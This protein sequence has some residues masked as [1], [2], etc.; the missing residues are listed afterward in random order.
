M[1]ICPQCNAQLRFDPAQQKLVCDYCEGIFDPESLKESQRGATESPSDTDWEVIVF[2]C[3]QCGGEVYSTSTQG[4]GFCSFCGASATLQSRMAKAKRPDFIIPF[5]LTKEDCKKILAKRL[6]KAWFLPSALRQHTKVDSFRGIYMPYYLYRTNIEGH[7]TLERDT[8]RR[9]GNYLITTYY[10]IE[11]DISADYKWVYF[12]SSSSFDDSISTS[13]APYDLTSLKPFNTNYFSG[14]YAD[15]ADLPVNLFY[16]L[17]HGLTTALCAREL[18]NDSRL[19]KYYVQS[20]SLGDTT[21]SIEETRYALFP[22]WFLA[23]RSLDRIA[24]AAINAQTGAIAIDLPVSFPRVLLGSLWFTLAFFTVAELFSYTWDFNTLTVIVSLVLV[25]IA[26]MYAKN[27][28]GIAAN[29]ANENDLGKLYKARQAASRAKANSNAQVLNSTDQDPQ[30]FDDVLQKAQD[31]AQNRL[32]GSE[33]D[34]SC[35]GSCIVVV[36]YSIFFLLASACWSNGGQF[37]CLMAVN[38]LLIYYEARFIALFRKLPAKQRFGKGLLLAM[39][40]GIG[41]FGVTIL[42]PVL[43]A[44][45]YSGILAMLGSIVIMMLEIIKQ[46]NVLATRR[47]PQFDMQGG[48]DDA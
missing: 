13:L 40:S 32:R 35:T 29:A 23:Y 41:S 48:D 44:W 20:S 14:F 18:Q 1:A 16:P 8:E 28:K 42:C 43:D 38:G 3:P 39:L 7:I 12:D 36:L 24:Y 31:R 34:S 11:G 45:Y 2:R 5:Q 6:A 22:V 21:T 19:T 4:A 46:Y 33:N 27:V 30:Q 10:E 9:K 47:L 26:R 25:L 17:T 37:F 15:T